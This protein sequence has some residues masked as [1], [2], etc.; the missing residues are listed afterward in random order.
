MLK[1]NILSLVVA[2]FFSVTSYFSQTVFV[3]GD[4]AYCV[5][6]NFEYKNCI[7]EAG[8]SLFTLDDNL[9]I[10]TQKG[11]V[12]MMWVLELADQTDTYISFSAFGDDLYEYVFIIDLS[13]KQL[14]FIVEDEDGE[15]YLFIYNIISK[16]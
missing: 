2:G 10:L 11:D 4:K 6:E 9:K 15:N 16:K 12:D 8:G 13:N 3:T 5:L 1:K 14:K 7:Q